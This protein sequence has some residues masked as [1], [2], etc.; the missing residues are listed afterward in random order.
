MK[1]PNPRKIIVSILCLALC[2]AT[3]I[4]AFGDYTK[5]VTVSFMVTNDMLPTPTSAPGIVIPTAT[6][7][8]TAYPV[9]TPRPTAFVNRDIIKTGDEAPPA[10]AIIVT[11][12]VCLLII[13][14]IYHYIKTKEGSTD[15]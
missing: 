2:L 14:V 13:L 9:L 6:P 12:A 4:T 3:G 15:V 10:A 7:M 1:R 8:P 5:D 11:I